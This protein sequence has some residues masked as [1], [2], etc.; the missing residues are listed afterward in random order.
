MDKRYDVTITCR[1]HSRGA[2]HSRLVSAEVSQNNNGWIVV[3]LWC[4]MIT[5]RLMLQACLPMHKDA[6]RK[7]LDTARPYTRHFASRP[8]AVAYSFWRRQD[9]QSLIELALMVPIFTILICYTVDL[10][11]FFLV[12]MSLTSAARN[13]VEY[14]IQGI[15]SRSQGSEPSASTLSSLAISSI[16]LTGVS[17]SNVSVQI[18]SASVGVTAVVNTTQCTTPSSGAGAVSGTADIDPETPIFQLNRVDVV[19]TVT[20]PIPIPAAVFPTTTFHRFVEMR[21]IQ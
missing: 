19:Y 10:G 17:T 21:G 15:S 7:K 18:C 16:G 13:T 12:A 9:G 3:A 1:L 14:S 2:A 11:F 4:S 20:P 6:M 5:L 8:A